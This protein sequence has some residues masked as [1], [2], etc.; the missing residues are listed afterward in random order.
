[1]DKSRF[2][3]QYMWSIVVLGSGITLLSI[4]QLPLR[5]LDFGFILLVAMVVISSQIAV[6]IP[7]VSGRIT[8]SDTFVF[9]TMLL[10]GGAAAVLMSALEGVCSS[11]RISRRTRTILLNS[12]VLAGSTFVTV[13]VLRFFFG[14]PRNI[15]TGGYSANFFIAICVMALVQY[16]ANT[17]LMR[18]KNPIRL[19]NPSGIHGRPI[20]C[21]RRSPTLPEPQPRVLLPGL[22]T[23]TAITRLWPRFQSSPLSTSLI[24]PT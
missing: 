1:M 15:V 7:R 10:Y 22:F 23:C 3:K 9:L 16:A 13:I 8:V 5:R 20:I 2:A 14:S 19:M 6:R 12:A 18:S 21:G 24:E 4:Y 17:T 11:L